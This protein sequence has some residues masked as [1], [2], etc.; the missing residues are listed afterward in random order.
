ME[1]KDLCSLENKQKIGDEDT[2]DDYDVSLS[3]KELKILQVEEYLLVVKELEE[4]FIGDE[5]RFIGDKI[6]NE[7]YNKSA[8]LDSLHGV[9]SPTII[10]VENPSIIKN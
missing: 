5:E 2:I 8:E 7:V 3:D 6:M 1:E 10:E 9:T 4:R